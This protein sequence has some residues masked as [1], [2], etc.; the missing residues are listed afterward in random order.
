MTAAP[1]VCIFCDNILG[2][3]TKPEHILLSALGGRKTTRR[4]LC[5]VHNAEFGG[6]IDDALTEQ[7]AFI[8]NQLQMESGTRKPPPG[9][10]R[11]K[12]G[13]ETV[14]IRSDGTPKL[15]AKP[16][17]ITPLAPGQ[18]QVSLTVNTAEEIETYLPHIAAQLGLPLEKAREQFA[19]GQA[20]VT[21]R[22]AGQIHRPTPLGGELECRSIVKA[23]LVLWATEVG[24]QEVKSE[25]YRAAREY[26]LNGGQ[27]LTPLDSR[28]L[29]ILDALKA[30]YGDFFN[31][32]YIRSDAQGRV[33]GHF[34]LYNLISWQVV[35]AEQGGIP[36]QKIALA[37]NPLDPKVWS[38]AIATQYDLGMDW[39]GVPD[40]NVPRTQARLAAALERSQRDGMARE[41][42]RIVDE[43]CLKHGVDTDKPITDPELAR[44]V[45]GEV[46]A[47]YAH[48]VLEIPY[49]EAITGAELLSRGGLGKKS[50]S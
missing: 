49:Q 5:G 38:D 14:E 46:A 12:A 2:P 6:G 30:R 25:P 33:I 27:F 34:T 10:G 3:D 11:V 1:P 17:E 48:H 44:R 41:F 28:P 21:S 50:K 39:L 40:F 4:V 43:V 36:D 8:R 26:V 47:R 9:L 7:V 32:I 42:A 13:K 18:F 29:P 45:Q 23:C 16:F 22:R 15:I 31:L 20:T 35:L 24:N 37:S 19:K